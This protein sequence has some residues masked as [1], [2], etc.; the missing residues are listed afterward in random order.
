[1]YEINWCYNTPTLTKM[2]MI[3]IKVTLEWAMKSQRGSR[4][5]ALLVL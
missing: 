4:G 5:V 2:K 1:L 3:K